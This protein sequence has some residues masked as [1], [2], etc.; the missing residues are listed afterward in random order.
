MLL[1]KFLE[2]KKKLLRERW[3]L[4]KFPNYFFELNKFI[5][6]WEITIN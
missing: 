2:N 6:T 5:D 1:K 3:A 4:F